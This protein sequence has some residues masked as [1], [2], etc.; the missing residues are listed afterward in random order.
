MKSFTYERASSPE[1]ASAAA[2]TRPAAHGFIIQTTIS[3]GTVS[4]INT[5]A[6]ERVPGVLMVTHLNEPKQAA[7]G[8]IE[9]PERYARSIPSKCEV[10]LSGDGVVSVKMTMTMTMTMTDIGTGSYTVLTQIAAEM[11]GLPIERVRMELGYSDFPA[12]PGFGGSWGVQR[13]RS[14]HSRVSVDARQG[15]CRAGDK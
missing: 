6:A 14:A 2:Q 5:S 4:A 11:L 13:Y 3:K 1:A 7:R 8:P 10:A 12:T 15:P 9:L